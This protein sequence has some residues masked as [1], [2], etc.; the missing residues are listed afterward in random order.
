MTHRVLALA[1][2]AAMLIPTAA[3]PC[4]P[5]VKASNVSAYD[6]MVTVVNSL[7]WAKEGLAKENKKTSDLTDRL[8]NMKSA[9]EDY[10]CPGKILGPFAFSKDEMIKQSAEVL[11]MGFDNLR[12]AN[13]LAEKQTVELIDQ[14]SAGKS[15]GQGTISERF[16]TMRQNSDGAWNELMQAIAVTAH[17]LVKYEGNSPSNRLRIT[18]AQ[19]EAL[20]KQLVET[21]GP[22]VKKGMQTGQ[23]YLVASGSALYQFLSDPK[24]HASDEK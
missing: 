23:T 24:W 21:L 10:A 3:R 22:S 19:R 12:Q 4:I 20:K 11:T 13:D 8:A 1:V 5:N 9:R 7:G 14:V 6:F 18:K 16:A 2:A 17:V 15:P